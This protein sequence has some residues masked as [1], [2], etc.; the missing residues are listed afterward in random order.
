MNG[1]IKAL[2]G[3][4]AQGLSSGLTLFGQELYQPSFR[5]LYETS[6]AQSMAQGQRQGAL[7][8]IN[9][10][11]KT[12]W[13]QVFGTHCDNFLEELRYDVDKWLEGVI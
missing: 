4:L 12:S 7:D 5:S 8:M 2:G 3:G 10:F 9:L 6:M 1:W 13:K 11:G